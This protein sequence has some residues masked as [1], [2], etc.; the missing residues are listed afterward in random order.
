MEQKGHFLLIKRE[1]L[2]EWL[3]K[4][5]ITREITKLQV[6]HTYLPNYNTRKVKNG[7]GQQDHFACLE[8]MRLSHLAEGFNDIGQNFT[9][10]ED[11]MI[12]YSLG[13]GLNVIPAGI[14]G[15]N[16]GAICIE[17]VGNFDKG[18][19]SITEEQRKTIVHLYACLAEKLNIPIDTNHIVYHVWYDKV[20]NRLTDYIPGK[21]SKTCPGT[22]FWGDGN[23]VA[24]ANKGFIPAVKAE[25]IKLIRLKVVDMIMTNYSKYFKDIEKDWMAP[26]VDA[27]KERGLIALSDDKMFHPNDPLSRGEFVVIIDR[28]VNAIISGK[29]F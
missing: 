1:E 8:G 18:G 14:K 11:G 9:T 25:Y 6:H 26:A 27:C 3:N 19:D 2:R 5:T 24:T 4:Q 7:V 28:L 17:N 29:K 23:T 10:F 12:G 21:S 13:R 16:Q 22:N 20:G 15:A